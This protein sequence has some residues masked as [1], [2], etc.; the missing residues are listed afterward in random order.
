MYDHFPMIP[1]VTG[2][3]ECLTFFSTDRYGMSHVNGHGVGHIKWHGRACPTLTSI[4]GGIEHRSSYI[5]GRGSAGEYRKKT[6]LLCEKR[7]PP[8]GQRLPRKG[9][10]HRVPGTPGV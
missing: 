3:I 9:E 4:P 5:L 8:L 2:F 1:A 7:W 10:I 6:V